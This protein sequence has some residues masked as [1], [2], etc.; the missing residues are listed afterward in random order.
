MT[1]KIFHFCPFIHDNKRPASSFGLGDL[2]AAD[3][4]QATRSKQQEGRK[5]INDFCHAIIV[6][7]ITN[8]N[9]VISA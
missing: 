2:V 8:T 4:K 7:S 1:T 5:L 9:D 6:S 3:G